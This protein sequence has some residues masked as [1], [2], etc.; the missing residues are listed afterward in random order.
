M[1]R[2][3][4]VLTL[5]SIV[6]AAAIGASLVIAFQPTVK[7]DSTNSSIASDVS[8]PAL[9][10]V[11][12]TVDNASAPFGFSHMGFGGPRGFGPESGRCGGSGGF[13]QVQVS[14]DFTLT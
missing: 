2:K 10:S 5:L 3:I 11:N 1:D 4:K 14:S 9:S 8:Q 13:G 7:A 6:I 12:S